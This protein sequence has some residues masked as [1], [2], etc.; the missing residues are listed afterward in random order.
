MTCNK[1]SNYLNKMNDVIKHLFNIFLVYSEGIFDEISKNSIIQELNQEYLK[2]SRGYVVNEYLFSQ[3]IKILNF[4]EYG[5]DIE[6]MVKNTPDNRG[7]FNSVL[8][9]ID[10]L[11]KLVKQDELKEKSKLFSIIENI[12]NY[13]FPKKGSYQEVF[14]ELQ[15]FY[16]E[17]SWVI[18]LHKSI[19]TSTLSYKERI[20]NSI[21]SI[22]PHYV[23]LIDMLIILFLNSDND[24]YEKVNGEKIF[25]PAI[26]FELLIEPYIQNIGE[27]HIDK[28]N[29]E[30]FLNFI[31][32]EIVEFENDDGEIMEY[33]IP[34]N[35]LLELL[36]EL[37]MASKINIK[38]GFKWEIYLNSETF[39]Q[40]YLSKIIEQPFNL[41]KELT[42][43]ICAIFANSIYLCI[44]N[45]FLS[46][47]NFFRQI[48]FIPNFFE[49]N[50]PYLGKLIAQ[51]IGLND[52]LISY[53]RVYRK[54]IFSEKIESEIYI[55]K[56]ID[57]INKLL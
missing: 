32:I 31:E 43:H 1:W 12:R 20:G 19:L 44:I 23:E 39:F 46:K 18:P 52:N 25:Y 56:L 28:E 9:T 55:Q 3:S 29:I 2:T 21:S 35:D 36:E 37:K 27:I 13:I 54:I 4:I 10:Y 15:K 41:T 48:F 6:I 45:K 22:P 50:I 49:S 7:Y 16:S 40:I 5:T 26:L 30:R 57:R 38:N 42:N 53:S 47:E 8:E 51:I 14:I 11:L 33:C 34:S 17:E 24:I